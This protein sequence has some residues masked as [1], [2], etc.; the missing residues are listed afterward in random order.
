MLEQHVIQSQGFTNVYD[1][2][3]AV[4]FRL[5]VRTPYY[6][7]VWLSLVE[8]AEVTVDGERF[9]RS[10]V[11]WILGG[12]RYTAA[13]LA[14]ATE[15]RWPFEEAAVLQVAKAGGLEPGLHE[16]EVRLTWRM[17]YMPI[18]M[19]PTT[20]TSSRKVTLVQ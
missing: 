11:D 7:G 3:R 20:H 1:G 2:A 6:R 13:E 8:G 12:R 4:A 15:A 19:Q 16:I 9:D 18:E 14:Q 17:S 5:R 10:G